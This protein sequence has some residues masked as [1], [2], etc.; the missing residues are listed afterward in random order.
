MMFVIGSSVTLGDFPNRFL[1]SCFNRCISFSWLAAF[2]LAL[3]FT[4]LV[5]CLPCYTRL[6]IFNRVSNL[7]DLV[8]DVFCSFRYA[9]FSSLCAFLSF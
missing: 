9:L 3:P 1:K 6:S 4:H 5:Y 2:S 7:I 8:L